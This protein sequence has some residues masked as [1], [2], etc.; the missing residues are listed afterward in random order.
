MYIMI[1]FFIWTKYEEDNNDSRK[2]K[3]QKTIAEMH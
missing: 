3:L 2:E 1:F